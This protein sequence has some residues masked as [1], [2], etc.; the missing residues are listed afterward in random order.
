MVVC[1][2]VMVVTGYI[3]GVFVRSDGMTVTGY[4]KIMLVSSY[5]V[6]MC[7]GSNR[8]LVGW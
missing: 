8:M 3:E 7:T 5:A 2:Y 4:V 6:I 1:G